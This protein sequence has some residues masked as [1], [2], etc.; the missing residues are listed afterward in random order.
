MADKEKKESLRQ[1]FDLTKLNTLS[2][3]SL[4]TS[5]TGFGALAGIITG[6]ISLAQIKDS[7]ENGRPLAIAGL[8]VGYGFL[9][10]FVIGGIA[11]AVLGPRYGLEFGD[12]MG[13]M[14]GQDG[15]GQNGGQFG[16]N[17]QMDD[18]HNDMRGFDGGMGGQ[19]DGPTN[20]GPNGGMMGD[21]NGQGGW[22]MDRNQDQ[23]APTP[24]ATK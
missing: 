8:V 6:H 4:A 2:V 20:M 17:G 10:L 3:V 9:A 24:S 14:M 19:I 23:P 16:M 11:R 18:M 7:K 13:G 21:P 5:V 1:R 12:R 22:M 15:F